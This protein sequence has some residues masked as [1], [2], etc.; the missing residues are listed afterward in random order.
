MVEQPPGESGKE[1]QAV[2]FPAG[3]KG[4]GVAFGKNATPFFL[5][6]AC[7]LPQPV[8]ASRSSFFHSQ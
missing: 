2:G 1:R 7:P 3:C 4:I 6:P 8:V 5:L